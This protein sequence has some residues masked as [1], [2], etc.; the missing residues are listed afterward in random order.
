MEF[1]NFDIY[2]D[3]CTRGMWVFIHTL[4]V[5]IVFSFWKKNVRDINFASNSQKSLVIFFLLYL[6]FAFDGGDYF[7][8]LYGIHTDNQERGEEIYRDI[9][10]FVSRNY[11]LF[12][13]IVWGGA[14]TLFLLTVKR[15]ELDIYKSAF[16]LFAVHISVFDYARASLAMSIYFYGISF[17][18]KPINNGKIISVLCGVSLAALSVYFHRS[19]A[20]IIPLTFMIYMPLNKKTLIILLL[21]F[22]VS[23][24]ILNSIL[25]SLMADDIYSEDISSKIQSYGRSDREDKAFSTF[26]WI[27]RYIQYLT[28]FIPFIWIT[29]KFYSQQ[30]V[31]YVSPTMIKLHKLTL[32]IILLAV[33]VLM[34]NISTFILFY[35]FLFMSMIP[36]TILWFYARRENL[37]SH[38][39]YLIVLY[40]AVFYKLFGF[41]KTYIGGSFA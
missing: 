12:R 26:E 27:R 22:A 35:R 5:F 1:Y 20:I 31:G 8:Y 14:L 41:L 25:N 39:I 18:I 17:L 7:H 34:T 16:L 10:I 11:L 4:F 9:A 21:L 23:S 37:V 24:P 29:I 33:S 30:F 40:L 13:T 36:L 28:F 2:A 19:M 3:G 38:K 15:L 32:G 6:L